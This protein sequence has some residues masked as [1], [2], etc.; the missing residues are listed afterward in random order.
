LEAQPAAG[1]RSVWQRLFGWLG[2]PL[3]ALALAG[4]CALLLLLLRP[5]LLGPSAVPATVILEATRGDAPGGPATPAGK[6][7]RLRL[8]LTG[9]AALTSFRLELA[10]SAG[11]P[12]ADFEARAGKDGVV[13]NLAPLAAGR[14][15]VRVYEPG[16]GGRLLREF[17]LPVK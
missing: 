7:V 15:W 11:A 16:A 6:P 3:P 2:R 8:D 17:A 1:R 14:Y 10:D 13:W 12:V 4:A 9:V 5:G